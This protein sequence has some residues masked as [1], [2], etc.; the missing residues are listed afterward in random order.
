MLENVGE[1]RMVGKNKVIRG[2]KGSGKK[3]H[4]RTGPEKPK[5]V[6]ALCPVHIRVN[7]DPGICWCIPFQS[8]KNLAD[9]CHACPQDACEMNFHA[10]RCTDGECN[11]AKVLVDHVGNGC[12][13]TNCMK[14]FTGKHFSQSILGTLASNAQT[15]KKSNVAQLTDHL[16]EQVELTK[17]RHIV[18][19]HVV[20]KTSLLVVSKAQEREELLK[21]K[22][23]EA[24]AKKNRGEEVTDK[25]TVM[26]EEELAHLAGDLAKEGLKLCHAGRL[27]RGVKPE[28]VLFDKMH[29]VLDIG[30][31]L[32]SV[33]GDLTASVRGRFCDVTMFSLSL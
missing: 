26:T 4:R 15:K 17:K 27:K 25:E 11:A 6:A 30:H 2:T 31:A 19:C 18:I 5:E 16:N 23:Q 3:Q 24:V 20:T 13:A 7:L 10:N 29:D 9:C 8:K 33:Q 32:D 28:H 1:E 22:M 14:Q 12:V 21:R